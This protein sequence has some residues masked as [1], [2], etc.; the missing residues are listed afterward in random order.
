AGSNICSNE[1]LCALTAAVYL[2]VMGPD[3]LKEAARQSAAKAH[4]LAQ[5]LT[6]INGVTLKYGDAFFHEFVTTMPKQEAVLKALDEAGILGGLPVEDGVLWCAT[7]KITKA[8]IDAAVD[9]VKEV[10]K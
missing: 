3:G 10:L 1:A 2:S 6:G 9:I 4:Y 8:E 5:Q 7:E